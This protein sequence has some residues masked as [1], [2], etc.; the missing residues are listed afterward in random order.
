MFAVFDGHNGAEAARFAAHTV[1]HIVEAFLPPW[2]ASELF[3]AEPA[4]ERLAVQLQE[5][6]AQACLELERQFA[7]TGCMS[8]CTATL[9]LQVGLLLLPT[10]HFL[11][12]CCCCCCCSF[13]S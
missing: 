5:G 13:C 4:E 7:M 2:G 1:A 9:V 10:L 12:R 6:L 3:P 11:R 8:G